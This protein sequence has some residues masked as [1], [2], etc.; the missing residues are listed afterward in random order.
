MGRAIFQAADD[1]RIRHDSCIPLLSAYAAAGLDTTIN[2][3]ANAVHL[4]A[5]HP[6]QWDLVR[7]DPGLVPSALNEVLRYE[8]P[9]QVFGRRTTRA[10]ETEDGITI[11]AGAQVLVLYGSGNRDERHY[12]EPDRFDVTRNPSDHL[13][14]GYGTHAC[15]GQALARIEAQSIIRALAKRARRIHIGRPTRHLN[16]TVRGLATLPVIGFEV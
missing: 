6:D 7:A 4:F 14:F 16:N 13:S 15:A 11:E 3:I 9:V 10:A 5:T 8:S 2:T 12:P 1:G